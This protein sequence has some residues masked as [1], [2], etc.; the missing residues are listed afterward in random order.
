[1]TL[2][3]L[4]QVENAAPG[5]YEIKILELRHATDQ[6][7][8]AGK[9]REVLKARGL[10]LLLEVI[11]TFQQVRLPQ[12]R[13]R[14]QV[15]TAQLLWA[16]DEKRASKLMADAIDGVKEYLDKVDTD[17]QDYDQTYSF[18]MQL[19]QEVLQALAPHDPEMALSFLRSTRTLINPNAGQN[20]G[21]PNQE[22]Q[23]ELQLASQITAADPKRAFQI[24]EDS[25]KKGYSS[26]LLDTLARLRTT[27]PELAARLAKEIAAKLQG[28]K[29]LKS[30]EA[31]ML[32]VNLLRFVRSPSRRNQTATT[33]AAPANIPLL[34]EQEYGDLFQKTLAEGLSY[35]APPTNN[36]SPERNAAQNILNSF[37][38]MG[39]EIE[40]LA[41]GS[42]AAVEEGQSNSILLPTRKAL[43]GSS[44]KTQ[45]TAALWKRRWKQPARHRERSRSTLSAGCRKSR[46]RRR[47]RPR[48][49]NPHGPRLECSPAPVCVG[50]YRSASD[51]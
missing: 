22:L 43:S 8:Q 21:Q 51:L 34:S 48:P 17:D 10:A 23:F 37:K 20:N 35:S 3:P 26:S 41:P 19:R 33:S 7:L 1:M 25:L 24:A 44:I 13:V 30:P 38:S 14:A 6:E 28:D 32:A 9:N 40:G 27:D 4:G 5:R 49:P 36:Y 47:L 16:S 29:L 50:Q 15:Q 12:T 39:S 45:L 31:A 18:A 2:L 46:S 42:T 11:D